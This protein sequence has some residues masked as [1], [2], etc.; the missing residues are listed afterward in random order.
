MRRIKTLADNS[1]SRGRYG[2]VYKAVNA[3]E[4]DRNYKVYNLDGLSVITQRQSDKVQNMVTHDGR[5]N[6]IRRAANGQSVG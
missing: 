3:V 1:S 6:S 2:R 5:I 4:R